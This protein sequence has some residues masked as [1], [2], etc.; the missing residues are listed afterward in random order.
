MSNQLSSALHRCLS[1]CSTTGKGAVLL[2]DVHGGAE[3]QLLHRQLNAPP[4]PGP[5]KQTPCRYKVERVGGGSHGLR[6]LV[7]KGKQGGLQTNEDQQKFI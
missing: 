4:S 2:Q 1:A 3:E 5:R 7:D 6:R